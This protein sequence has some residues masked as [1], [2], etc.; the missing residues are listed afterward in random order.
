MG[1][2][3]N[4]DIPQEQSK[5]DDSCNICKCFSWFFVSFFLKVILHH[6][7]HGEEDHELGEKEAT[8]SSWDGVVEMVG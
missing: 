1:E 3:N 6:Y 2:A 4:Y 5:S 7:F 8:L